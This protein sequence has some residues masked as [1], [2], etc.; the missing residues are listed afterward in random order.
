VFSYATWGRGRFA[1]AQAGCQNCLNAL[2]REYEKLVRFV[3]V[4]QRIMQAEW[5]D[6]AQV[7]FS[8]EHDGQILTSITRDSTGHWLYSRYWVSSILPC[9][10]S[11]PTNRCHLIET[12]II[13]FDKDL[14]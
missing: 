2:L 8:E 11:R 10:K 5:A 13:F 12:A 14:A 9:H 6:L 4:R 7:W 3:I 1:Y